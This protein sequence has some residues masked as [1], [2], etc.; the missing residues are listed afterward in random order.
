MFWKTSV[1]L[2]R[3]MRISKKLPITKI[4][5]KR[6]TPENLI[7]EDQLASDVDGLKKKNSTVIKM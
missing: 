1:V 6:F 7:Q 3:N 4:L 2:D 5:W